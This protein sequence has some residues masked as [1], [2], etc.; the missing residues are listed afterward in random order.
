MPDM[1]W[2]QVLRNKEVVQK[3]ATTFF[4]ENCKFKWG[5]SYKFGARVV[6]LDMYNLHT[7]IMPSFHILSFIKIFSV[8]LSDHKFCYICHILSLFV[9]ISTKSFNIERKEVVHNSSLPF[10]YISSFIKVFSV[11]FAP[12]R[13]PASL[14]MNGHTE[15]QRVNLVVTSG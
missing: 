8:L 14:W 7:V 3:K 10:T 15:G 4:K 13:D 9:S 6:N 5:N 1:K 11:L 12:P 2:V